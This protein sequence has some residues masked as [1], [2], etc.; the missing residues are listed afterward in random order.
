MAQTQTD[1]VTL[2]DLMRMTEAMHEAQEKIY[3]EITGL[4]IKVFGISF[5]VAFAVSIITTIIT[6]VSFLKGAH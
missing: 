3:N 6:L 4:K 2:R 1:K 5:G